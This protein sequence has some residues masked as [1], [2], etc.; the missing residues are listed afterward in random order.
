MDML[1]FVVAGC[2]LQRLSTWVARQISVEPF[3]ENSV[4]MER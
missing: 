3:G 2:M 4:R 1:K